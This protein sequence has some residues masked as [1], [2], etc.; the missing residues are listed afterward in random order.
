M[1]LVMDFK[2]TLKVNTALDGPVSVSPASSAL[3]HCI[4]A[5]SADTGHIGICPVCQ[6]LGV[7]DI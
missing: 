3:P 1:S 6:Y 2:R 4:T 5:E 7:L